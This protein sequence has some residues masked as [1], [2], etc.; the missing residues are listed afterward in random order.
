LGPFLSDMSFKPFSESGPVLVIGADGQVGSA[1]FNN[2]SQ[3]GC[4]VIGTTRHP[5]R[6]KNNHVFLDLERPQ[7][8]WE[9]LPKAASFA[10]ISAAITSLDICEK[11]PERTERVNI[12]GPV[13]LARMLMENGCFVLFLSTTGVFDFKKPFRKHD[14]PTCPTTAYG[15]QKAKAEEKILSME[16]KAAVLRLTKVMGEEMPLLKA[17][18]AKLV[19][20]QSIAAFSDT[21]ISPIGMMFTVDLIKKILSSRMSGVFHASGDADIPYSHFAEKLVDAMGADRR[22][23]NV[24]KTEYPAFP[25]PYTSLDMSKEANLYGVLPPSAM[26]AMG[27]AEKNY[28]RSHSA[29][30]AL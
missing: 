8:S 21:T 12:A 13:D 19:A 29:P 2:L 14:E 6:A 1:L 22:L 7:T 9:E 26:G 10:V 16:G 3:G 25:Q 20:G 5:E 24:C 28:A 27:E 4:P 18:R 30:S 17:W 11:E 15:R 23:I